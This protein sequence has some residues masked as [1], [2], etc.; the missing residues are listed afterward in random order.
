MNHKATRKRVA[1]FVPAASLPK[2][3]GRGIIFSNPRYPAAGVV[4]YM[5]RGADIAPRTNQKN[6][7]SKSLIVVATLAAFMGFA[8]AED[9]KEPK[10]KK[11][12]TPEQLEKFDKD[13]DGKL[14]KEERA[15]MKKADK[16]KPEKKPK[17]EKKPK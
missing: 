5:R 11:K 6:M 9:T 15:E 8:Q 14:S 7:K 3:G 1:F 4:F 10:L 16:P 12:P 17:G 13:K 2:V